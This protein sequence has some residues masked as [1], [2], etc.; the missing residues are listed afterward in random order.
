MAT[1]I[2]P[3][4]NVT[5]ESGAAA[6][7]AK[8]LEKKRAVLVP[9]DGNP[10]DAVW[11]DRPEPL[12]V[13]QHLGLLEDVVPQ[14]CLRIKVVVAQDVGMRAL[15]HLRVRDGRESLDRFRANEPFGPWIY[16][17]VTNLA[18][19]DVKGADDTV[20][21]LS[22]HPGVSVEEVVEA[23]GFT[24]DIPAEVPT[25]REPTYAELV[26]IREMLDPKGLRFREVPEPEAAK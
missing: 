8:A 23:T 6:A 26:I 22:V 1:K 14:R 4:K 13:V 18:V 5:K 10:V 17:I 3:P 20:R 16:R 12:A 24:L 21:L 19:L 2:P 11:A 15:A 25:T 7:A 9:V